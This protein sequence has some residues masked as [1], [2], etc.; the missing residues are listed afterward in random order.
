M[1]L[2]WLLC[3]FLVSGACG[4]VYEVV[5]MRV[6]SLTLSVTVYAVTTVL[7]AYMGGLAVGA[8]I[9]GRIADRLPRPLVVFGL[10]EMG[11]GVLGLLVPRILFGIGPVEIWL[12][13]Y[14]GGSG[15]AYGAARFAVAASVLL[16]PCTLMGMTLPLLSRAAVRDRDD[17]AVGAGGLYAFNSLGAVL[18]CLASGYYLIPNLGLQATSTLAA[19]FNLG[20]GLAAVV[21]GMR[22]D[23]LQIEGP[24][25]P[26]TAAGTPVH[27]SN[28]TAVRL[29][30]VAFGVSGFTSLGL[31][32]LWTRA[33]EQFTHNST[34]A[35]T[36]MLAIFLLG[37]GGGSALSSRVANRTRR[38]LFAFGLLELAIGAS[39]IVSLLIYMN[40]LD[41]IPAVTAA[42][43]GLQS[44]YR[45]VAMIFG[46]AVVTMLVTTTLFGATF[47]Y[48][49]RAV[50]ERVDHIG[51][52][53]ATAYAV[54]TVGAILG[55]V[56]VG[57]IL[58]PSLGLRDSFAVLILMNLA[59]GALLV[60]CRNAGD[61]PT[62]DSGIA[63]DVFGPAGITAIGVAIALAASTF[64]LLPQDLFKDIYAERYHKLLM[65]REQ[66][67]DIVMVTEDEHGERMIRY[68]DGRGTA[69]T[70]TYR[71]DRSYAHVALMFHPK[72]ER[73][74]NICFGVGNSLSSVTQ[75]PVKS[76]VQ[77]ELSPGVVQAAPHFSR[78]NRNVLQDPRVELT[79]QDGRNYLLTS[80]EQFDII[81]LDPPELHTRG[82]VNLYTKEFFE[83]ARDHLAKDGIFSIWVNIAYTP[84]AEMKMI[85]RTAK[86]V[87]PHVT[88]WQSPWLYSW[89]INGSVEE[90]PLDLEIMMK[91]FEDPL[92]GADL[93]SIPYKSAFDFLNYFVMKDDDIV[94]FAGDAPTITDDRTRLDFTV[95]RAVESFFGISNNITDLFLLDQIDPDA[96]VFLRGAS[97]C[98]YKQRVFPHVV[99]HEALG[100]SASELEQKLDSLLGT[101]LGPDGCVGSAQAERVPPEAS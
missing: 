92:I 54:N 9:A 73:I 69:G 16:V 58:L 18:G 80:K 42:T 67:T 14:L 35:Y 7:C 74:L 22:S 96:D 23:A 21:L 47:P 90:T 41:W 61:Q 12:H 87:F 70:K 57:F 32:V 10:A 5:W 81:R 2:R 39:V 65:Y 66:V 95:P 44:W 91:R 19:L 20:L 71:E 24:R 76:I 98:R 79:I 8:A 78:T 11:I 30:I 49:A 88:I 27:G 6:L 94:E 36:S 89:V 34:Y 13:S 100:L 31:E 25:E 50:V 1:S 77:V 48:V 93:A 33:L 38:P 43:G 86:E 64:I 85:A 68:G 75:Y 83:L 40:L 29:A 53:I 55:S 72:P 45:A 46:V 62:T 59:L 15:F 84:E 56:I 82:I 52:R 63:S 17:V 101:Q 4:L 28:R 51:H 60:A 97:Y 37:I 26:S 3:L 99:N